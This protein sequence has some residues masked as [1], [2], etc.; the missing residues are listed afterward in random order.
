[1]SSDQKR[2][3]LFVGEFSQFHTG[4][5]GYLKEIISRLYET[6]KYEVAE[7]GVYLPEGH[8][9]GNEVP[10][11]VFANQPHPESPKHIIDAYNSNPFNVFGNWRFHET[12]LDFKPDIVINIADPWM[13]HFIN[14][15]PLRRNFKYLHMPTVDSEPQKVE[16][17]QDYMK[18]DGI[19]TYS[20]FGRR[21]LEF[22][23]GGKIPVLGVAS[24]GSDA[25]LFKPRNK[26]EVRQ[27]FNP[28]LNDKIIIQT[29]MRNQPR[30]L[31]TQLFKAFGLFLHKCMLAGRKDIADRCVL[32]IH[33]CNPDV[34]WSLPDEIINHRI[35]N[36]V[37]LTYVCDAC[38]HVEI[39]KYKHD[40]TVCT[41]C[42]QSSLRLVNSM[43]G[44]DRATLGEIMSMAD[45][46]VQYSVCEGWGMPLSDAKM[47]G[48]PVAAVDYS[49][50]SEQAHS[51]GGIPIPVDR[52][53]QE[54]L[55]QTYALRAFP[56]NEKFA[57]ILFD[58]FVEGKIDLETKGREARELAVAQY[59]W[60]KVA[61]IWESAIDQMT[62]P[63]RE[64]TWYS[65]PK[66]MNKQVA[67]PE[68]LNK[69]QL[70]QFL[71]FEVLQQPE[72][73]NS[74]WAVERLYRL[75]SG[76][77]SFTDAAGLTQ[78][79]PYGLKELINEI[80]TEVNAYNRLEDAR[81]QSAFAGPGGNSIMKGIF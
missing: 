45:L 37:Y 21:T 18:C 55:N 3:I 63:P 29:V 46:Y 72:R 40:R 61:K 62:L 15:S 44:V 54:P 52:W 28:S 68:N 25:D 22:Q 50:M 57:Q 64:T 19:L 76:F 73:L 77:E 16:W 74:Q 20:H 32:H 31:Y 47:C 65:A 9:A 36:K 17:I 58:A 60:D 43:K 75:D 14:A 12:L 7:L 70:L 81:L 80:E 6:N 53:N 59:N 2:R 38:G 35:A 1:M 66:F 11:K 49:A 23:S 56:D 67:L 13:Q 79:K 71:A 33:T 69:H 34:G 41:K 4:F 5:A 30:K 39:A 42:H 78:Q 51:P 27:K 26:T 10:W 8:P 24:P 48:V